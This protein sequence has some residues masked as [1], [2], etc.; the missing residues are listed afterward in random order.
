MKKKLLVSLVLFMGVG[1]MLNT[2]VSAVEIRPV[3]NNRAIYHN[4]TFKN[5]PPKTYKGLTLIV[6]TKTKTGYI[7]TYI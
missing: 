6:V 3:I 5:Y 2:T 1:F 4:F 7:G